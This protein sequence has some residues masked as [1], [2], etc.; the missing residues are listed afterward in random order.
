M[1][2]RV[3]KIKREMCMAKVV[4]VALTA[5]AMSSAYVVFKAMGG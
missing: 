5:L 1:N 2:E 4:L 3:R